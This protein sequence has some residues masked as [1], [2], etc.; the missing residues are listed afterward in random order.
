MEMISIA[1]RENNTKRSFLIVNKL[2]G[3]HFPVSPTKSL[4]LFSELSKKI[5]ISDKTLV[6]GFCETATA[7]GLHIAKEL[8]LPYIHTTREEY[9]TEYIFFSEEHSH[10]TEQKLLKHEI[11]LIIDD[12]DEILFVE[13]EITTGKTVLNIIES[14]KKQYTKK[15]KFS[16]SAIINGMNE[17]NIERFKQNDIDVFYILETNSLKYDAKV[18]DTIADGTVYDF[19][20][21]DK[22]NILCD[23]GENKNLPFNLKEYSISGFVDAR[24]LLDTSKYLSQLE[25]LSES[26][27]DILAEENLGKKSKIL[28]LGTEELMYPAIFVGKKIE[29]LGYNV[30]THS[31]TRS[32]I[33]VSQVSSYPLHTRYELK[34]PYDVERKTFVYN[35]EKYDMVFVITEQRA[36]NFQSI[37]DALNISNDNIRIVRWQ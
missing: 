9:D 19:Y 18:V 11:D 22:R 5:Q 29:E 28:F 27:K 15:L 8:S 10:A 24:K 14:F 12:I 20:T 13:D 36:K 37:I 6:I 25:I 4:A 30:L 35:L 23:C 16:V 34:S 31:T 32:P 7:I 21:D 26:I 17:E 1:K 3:K 2:Q 33:S